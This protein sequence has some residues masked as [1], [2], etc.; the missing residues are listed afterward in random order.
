[1]V[2][3]GAKDVGTFRMNKCAKTKRRGVCEHAL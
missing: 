1:M 2:M 3:D